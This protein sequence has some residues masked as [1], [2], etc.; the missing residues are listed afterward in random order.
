MSDQSKYWVGFNLVRGI[1]A[2]RVRMLLAA[3]GDLQTAWQAPSNALAAAGLGEKTLR[4]LQQVRAGV[5]LDKVLET[6]HNQGIQVMTWDDPGYPRWLKEID[7]PPPTLYVRGEFTEADDWA[8]AIVGTRRVTAYGRQVA[9]ELA[10]LL[11]HS[12]VT[13]V[14]GLARGVDSIAHQASLQAGGRTIAVLGCGID[15]IYPP[16]NRRLA[17]AIQKSGALISDYPP[18]T[19]PDAINFPPRNRIIS[20]L[21]RAV[22]IVEA[23]ETSG[24]LITASFAADQG[25]DV[26]AV[27]GGIYAPQSKGANR[28]IQQGARPL[29]NLTDVLEEL[30][31]E[32][33]QEQ[34]VVRQV[35]PADATEAALFA[36]LGSEP[37]HVDELRLQAG[38]PVDKVTAALTMLEL[39]GLVRQVG[40]MNY[41][42]IREMG[43]V[44]GE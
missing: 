8:V 24:A 18:G 2:A 19:P 12:K 27:P 43:E 20:G 32:F 10:A 26:F 31:L 13:V 11:A 7:L 37:V 1:G 3:F 9:E 38:L 39:K 35:I 29:L 41:I 30:D 36:L 23:G 40:G 34:K 21:A 16:E 5:S 15:R 17:D 28:L 42:A 14:S 6:L 25:R 22:V 44:Y 33:V 4:G